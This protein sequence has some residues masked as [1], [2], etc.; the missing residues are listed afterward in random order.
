MNPEN[1]P[2]KKPFEN[3][4]NKIN[5][6]A[7]AGGPAFVFD[8][9]VAIALVVGI[10]VGFL[11]G[12]GVGS[13][14][15]GNNASSTGGFFFGGK[16]SSTAEVKNLEDVRSENASFVTVNEQAAGNNVVISNLTLDNT[17]WVAVRDSSEETNT[18][19]ILGARRVKPGTYTDLS[20]FVSRNTEA[21]KKYEVV[22]YK[23]SV[24][25]NY[26]ASSLLTLNDEVV[27]AGFDVK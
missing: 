1:S 19:F 24:D 27:R 8:K 4:Q 9:F 22:F 23:D 6:A 15:A 2:F 3:I 14:S 11:I 7:N 18:P 26:S 20:V 12:H 10:V 25:F 17:Y 16:S 13:N 5:N 21:G